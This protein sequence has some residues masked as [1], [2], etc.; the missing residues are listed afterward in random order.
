M[1]G[2]AYR[3]HMLE[4]HKRRARRALRRW[5]RDEPDDDLVGKRAH[6]RCACSCW[7]CGH[8]REVLG[9]T[10]QE[11]RTLLGQRLEHLR[12]TIV[13]GEADLLDW[14]DTERTERTF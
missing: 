14:E 8:Q 3:R 6:T 11:R 1:R 5:F 4:K 9:P 10:V 13:E 2:L 12:R 7:M